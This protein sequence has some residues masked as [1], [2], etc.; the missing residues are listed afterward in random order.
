MSLIKM[1]LC[2]LQE[3]FI[4]T[5]NYGK[6]NFITSQ[7]HKFHILENKELAYFY[8]YNTL[9]LQIWKHQIGN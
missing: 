6:S 7:W 4:A 9:I 8:K 5:H 3:I 2:N 1:N